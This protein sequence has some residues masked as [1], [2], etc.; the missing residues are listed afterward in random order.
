M[1]RGDVRRATC[2]SHGT[3]VTCQSVTCVTTAR[4]DACRSQGS[5][6]GGGGAGPEADDDQPPAAA[7]PPPGQVPPPPGGGR[8]RGRAR[9]GASRAWGDH[10]VYHWPLPGM[11]SSLGRWTTWTDLTGLTGLTLDDLDAGLG[12]VSL[13]FGP[14]PFHLVRSG[15]DR[16]SVCVV[17]GG[18]CPPPFLLDQ[19]GWSD[20]PTYL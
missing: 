16:R 17:E 9:A 12:V 8:L 14:N 18:G 13:V 3:H 20:P 7:E 15:L 2:V 4:G 6:G 5:A 1:V 10:V 19:S 11:P